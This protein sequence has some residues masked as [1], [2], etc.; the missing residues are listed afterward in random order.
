MSVTKL[1][2]INTKNFLGLLKINVYTSNK[3]K[4]SYV[5]KINKCKYLH[6]RIKICKKNQL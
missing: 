5:L 1:K 3:K 4:N 2:F 6:N